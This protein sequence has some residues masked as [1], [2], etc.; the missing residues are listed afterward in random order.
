MQL[1]KLRGDTTAMH[2]AAVDDR[3]RYWPPPLALTVARALNNIIK[4]TLIEHHRETAENWLELS[5]LLGMTL[6]SR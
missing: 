1:E 6:T 5:I 3:I 4:Q 2:V